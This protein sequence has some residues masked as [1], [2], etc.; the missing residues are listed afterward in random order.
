MAA[1]TETKRCGQFAIV[2]D[3]TGAQFVSG[4]AE[5]MKDWGDRRLAKLVSGND[6]VLRISLQHQPDIEM[7][8]LVLMQTD[9]AG[10]LGHQQM[11]NREGSFTAA[12]P[13]TAKRRRR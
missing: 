11:V 13:K 5:Y 7:C 10:W 2:E 4:P 3:G 9:Y 6:E 1:T 8:I 12:P